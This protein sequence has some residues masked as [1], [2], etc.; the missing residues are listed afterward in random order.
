MPNLISLFY[1]DD[2]SN[3]SDSVG[4]LQKQFNILTK[5]CKLYRVWYEGKY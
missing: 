2:I 1:A 4:R 5:Y 3:V